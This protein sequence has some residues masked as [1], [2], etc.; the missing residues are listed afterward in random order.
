MQNRETLQLLLEQGLQLLELEG[1]ILSCSKHFRCCWDS[2]S[3]TVPLNTSNSQ[4]A[5]KKKQTNKHPTPPPPQTIRHVLEQICCLRVEKHEVWVGLML[6]TAWD[7]GE[8]FISKLLAW[9]VEW[10]SQCGA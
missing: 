9:A 4:M 7:Y 2:I 1:T 8:C 10:F 6:L 3:H 5:L